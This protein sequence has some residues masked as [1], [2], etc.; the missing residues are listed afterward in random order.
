[1]SILDNKDISYAYFDGNTVF[2]LNDK[3]LFVTTQYKVMKNVT[4]PYFVRCTKIMCNGE[5]QLFYLCNDHKRFE[6]VCKSEKPSGLA[7][8]IYKL[9]AALKNIHLNGFLNDGN[10]PEKTSFYYIDTN[11]REV[12]IVY[13]PLANHNYNFDLK[14]FKQELNSL[15]NKCNLGNEKSLKDFQFLLMDEHASFDLLLD[16][17]DQTDIAKMIKSEKA[18]T[19]RKV[20]LISRDPI[21]KM[22]IQIDKKEYLIGRNPSMVDGVIPF[23]MSIGRIHAKIMETGNQHWIMD[24]NSANGTF[25]NGTRLSPNKPYAIMNGDIVS[26]AKCDFEVRVGD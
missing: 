16:Y 11:T 10:I 14:L 13:L 12:K 15:L 25:L 26:F 9:M 1:M 7:E 17:W 20:Q 18:R 24:L 6:D 3:D 8:Y 23:N 5:D 2:A 21:N 19:M 22:T 4:N